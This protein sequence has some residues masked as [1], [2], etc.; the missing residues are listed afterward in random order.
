MEV[1][2]TATKIATTRIAPAALTEEPVREKMTGK[3]L[4]REFASHIDLAKVRAH[5]TSDPGRGV[6]RR[7][8][9]WAVPCGLRLR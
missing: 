3:G 6:Q 4:T 1:T 7:P 2:N 9:G 8:V 5:L